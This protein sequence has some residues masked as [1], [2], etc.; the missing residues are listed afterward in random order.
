MTLNRVTII[1]PSTCADERCETLRRAV[2]S[3][4]VQDVGCPSILIVANGPRV[5][6]AL[7]KEIASQPQIKVL[8]LAEGSVARAQAMGRA[9]VFT[10]YFGF[11]DDDDE[12]SPDALR[13][14]LNALEGDPEAAACATDGY[15][16]TDG[17]DQIR[18]TISPEAQQDPLRGLLRGNWLAS[19][20]GL[21]R[22]HLVPESFFD[23]VT[24]YFE[25]TLLA[26]KL[27]SSR[28]VVLLNT[29]TYRLYASA[30]SLSR[31]ENYRLAEPEVL[32]KICLLDLPSDVRRAVR[33]RVGRAYHSLSGHFFRKGQLHDA[34]GF[35]A[36]SLL[37]PD[38]WRY[39][40][41]TARLLK[42]WA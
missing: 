33:Q 39:A 22:S 12:Y 16:F 6:V 37:Q 9:H 21:F 24:Q 8:R 14:R 34:W 36:R 31:S 1:I 42:F 2:K 10:S 40:S 27:A 35:H 20:G 18:E 17:I 38:G 29:P 19:C 13:L 25:W 15:D 23:G 28:R 11:L 4:S 26:Y 32:K 3:L 7:L 30:G 5:N 41:Y